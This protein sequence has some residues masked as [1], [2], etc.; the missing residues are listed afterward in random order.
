METRV[1]GSKPR[2]GG[3]MLQGVTRQSRSPARD[4]ALRGGASGA[5]SRKKYSLNRMI[6]SNT[7]KVW[8]CFFLAL[9]FSV[10]PHM[11]GAIGNQDY[12]SA[13]EGGHT[14]QHIPP[15]EGSQREPTKAARSKVALRTPTV[16][17]FRPFQSPKKRPHE[18]TLTRI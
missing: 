10:A 1:S 17:C 16:N 8:M 5:E 15:H 12:F 4:L 7:W 18:P 13:Q 3:A 11:K 14:N 2:E 9:I 6:W